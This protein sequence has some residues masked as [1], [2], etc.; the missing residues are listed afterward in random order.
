[1]K[2]MVFVIMILVTI[3]LAAPVETKAECR[4]DFSIEELDGNFTFWHECLK[5]H[6][7]EMN[8]VT[9]AK[10]YKYLYNKY[11][12]CVNLLENGYGDFSRIYHATTL[13]E[14]EEIT[15]IILESE[16]TLEEIVNFEIPEFIKEDLRKQ[17]SFFSQKMYCPY[18]ISMVKETTN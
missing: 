14:L 9:Y 10:A 18:I 17:S 13:W 3:M 5:A 6:K 2:K 7:E 16:F 4:S 15:G 12:R 1:M 11:Y 8:E